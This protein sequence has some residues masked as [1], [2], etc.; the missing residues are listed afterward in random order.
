MQ[1]LLHKLAPIGTAL[2]ISTV[3]AFGGIG[4]APTQAASLK[5]PIPQPN[6]NPTPNPII[7]LDPVRNFSFTGSFANDAD[8][9]SFFFTTNGTSTVTLRTYSYAGGTNAAGID[10]PRGGFDPILSLFDNVG[11]L[12]R[13][14][15]DGPDP[16]PPDSV[17]GQSYDTNFSEVLTAGRYRV[18][19]SQYDNFANGPTFAD[20]FRESSPTFT[21]R[22][23]CSN[24]Q[25]CDV[26]SDN[27]TN[28]WAFDILNVIDAEQKDIPDPS[29]ILG[30]I[31]F[32]TIGVASTRKRK[33]KQP[34]PSIQKETTRIL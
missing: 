33:L 14:V 2:G 15:D 10:I 4:I 19:V 25:F 26:T 24:G 22:Y 18:V 28:Q 29:S 32:S 13:T 5:A 23:G 7:S 31:A 30:L 16:V 27:R 34:S 1:K 8:T 3:A 21:S 12:I 9:Q 11:N 6:V 20:G 17:T